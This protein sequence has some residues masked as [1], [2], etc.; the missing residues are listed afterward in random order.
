MVNGVRVMRFEGY[1][2]TSASSQ[3]NLYAEVKNT[4]SGDYV[5]R[6]R[7]AKPSLALATTEALRLNGTA[8][9]ALK[10]QLGL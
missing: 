3:N 1:A 4:G 7:Q 6:V 2:P 8:W 9:A 10:A 5:Y